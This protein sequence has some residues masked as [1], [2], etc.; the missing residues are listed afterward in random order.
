[1]SNDQICE[2]LKSDQNYLAAE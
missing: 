2:L 1:M